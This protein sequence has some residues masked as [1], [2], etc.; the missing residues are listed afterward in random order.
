MQ[1]LK[2]LTDSYGISGCEEMV[3]NII[4]LNLKNNNVSYVSHEGNIITNSNSNADKILLCAHMDEVGFIITDITE[5]GFLKFDIVG[6]IDIKTISGK[7]II[8]GEKKLK[9]LYHCCQMIIV[10]IILKIF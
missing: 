2:Q 5:K 10:I 3:A 9:E 6:G 1:L 7:C 8:I 4:K